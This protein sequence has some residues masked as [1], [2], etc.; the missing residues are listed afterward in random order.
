MRSKVE[1]KASYDGMSAWYDL[2]AGSS[3]KRYRDVGLHKLKAKEG[4]TVL[5]IGFGT[6]HCLLALAR[7]VGKSGKAYGIDLSEGM[8]NVAQRRLLEAGMSGRVELTSGDACALPYPASAFDAIFMSFTL[9]LFDTPEIPRVLRE[10]QRV[11]ETGGRICVVS[12]SKRGWTWWCVPINGY[13]KSLPPTWIA[14]RSTSR[15]R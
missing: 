12:L 11:L 8:C 13:T 6:G 15:A 10:C 4:E 2:L 7:A 14:A 3:E 9:E 5:E 1:A